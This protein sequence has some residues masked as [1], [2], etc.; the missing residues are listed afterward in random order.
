MFSQRLRSYLARFEN[1]FMVTFFMESVK[2]LELALMKK[3]RLDVMGIFVLS[4]GRIERDKQR[5]YSE[6]RIM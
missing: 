3:E 6:R 2:S 4:R 5:L 1:R